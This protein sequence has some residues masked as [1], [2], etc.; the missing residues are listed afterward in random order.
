MTPYRLPDLDYDY[1]ALEP[2]ISGEIMELHHGKHH[3]AYVEKANETLEKIEEARAKHDFSAIAGLEGALA[4]NVSGHVL[5]SIFWKN[6][7]RH[8]GGTPTGALGRC[9]DRDFGGFEGLK[10]QLTAAAAT[11][12]GSGWASLAWEPTGER[13][14][15]AQILDHQ[16]NVVQGGQTLMVIDGWEHAY[17]LQYKNQKAKFFEAVWSLWNWDD[18]SV[19][20][21]RAQASLLAPAH[22]PSTSPLLAARSR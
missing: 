22:G 13:L 12:M 7:K 8:G 6:L 9:I 3:K 17:Y 4:F 15:T 2:Q 1:G 5:H 21:E 16:S 10:A 11:L 18:V 19:R 14:V 20:L